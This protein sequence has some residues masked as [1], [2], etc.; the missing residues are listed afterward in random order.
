METFRAPAHEWAVSRFGINIPPN[1]LI[2]A[3][4]E[5]VISCKTLC[6]KETAKCECV[7]KERMR[8]N[9]IARRAQF[10]ASIQHVTRRA[11]LECRDLYQHGTSPYERSYLYST[12]PELGPIVGMD[13]RGEF[14]APLG[15]VVP[16]EIGVTDLAAIERF[17]AEQRESQ[18][19]MKDQIA[20]L[21]R[22]SGRM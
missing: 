3:G 4:T 16:E 18:E 12:H 1:S 7:V 21:R 14:G 5:V 2:E 6:G 15:P 8:A 13:T 20:E 9:E 22:R 10:A 19:R 11:C 17:R